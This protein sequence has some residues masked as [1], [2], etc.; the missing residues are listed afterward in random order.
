[1]RSLEGWIPRKMSVPVRLV[2]NLWTCVQVPV[3]GKS[4]PV[5]GQVPALRLISLLCFVMLAFC[6]APAAQAEDVP[7]QVEKPLFIRG[8][9]ISFLQEIE[10]HGGV[11]KENGTARNL[12]QILKDHGFNYARLRIW[13][14]PPAGYCGIE[15]TLVM[16]AR[17]KAEGLGLLLDFH[18]SDT[19]A[20]PGKQR[21]P[22]AW[23]GSDVEALKDSVFEYAR[24]VIGR[25]RDNNALPD[26]VQ[27]GNEIICGMLWDDGR[28]CGP[29]DT[30]EQWENLGSLV[31][32]GIRGVDAALGP[33]D[34]IDIV[35]H[36]D[37]GA[38][39]EG[40]MW[41]FDR[42]LAEGVEFDIIGLSYY[43]WWHG[44]L[45]EVEANLEALAARYPKDILIVETA[46]PWTLKWCDDMHNMIGLPDQLHKG[47]PA[48]VVGQEAFLADLTDVVA[49]TPAS[50]GRGVFYWAPEYIS[51]AGMGSP[52]ENLTL[53]DF[54]GSLLP[55]VAAFDS[56]VSS[57]P[58][59]DP[60]GK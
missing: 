41:F 34:S 30:P 37:R 1:M 48:T 50:R 59:A 25:L 21:K 54:D 60:A 45:T 6:G 35:I 32:E 13:H 12:L 47:Y 20:D 46:Y 19:W 29:L 40:S 18:Y 22:R 16:A 4:S 15:S 58:P 36:I 38:D 44:T 8:A 2:N 57:V 10:N 27:I 56:L 7:G 53:F 31:A 5:R 55:S 23:E 26:M 11:F 9:D 52:W 33:G 17:V 3:T 28:V 39:S 42:L 51:V 24:A 49:G 14:T 43:P